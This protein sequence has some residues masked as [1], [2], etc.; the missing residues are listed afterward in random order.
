MET[1]AL[2][3]AEA[4]DFSMWS[5]FWRATL[6]VKLVMIGLLAA[7]VLVWAVWLQ[8]IVQFRAAR[9]KAAAFDRVFWS[10]DPPG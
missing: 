10:G 5:L 3:G 2:A 4:V 8:K 1:V 9:R 6:V 7:S